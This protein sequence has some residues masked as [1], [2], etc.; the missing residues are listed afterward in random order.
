ME[1]H[2]W[3]QRTAGLLAVVGVA[4]ILFIATATE[5]GRVGPIA[6]QPD[7]PRHAARMSARQGP[8]HT[9]ACTPARRARGHYL[10]TSLTHC[11][12]CHSEVSYSRAHPLQ[13]IP[14]TMGSGHVFPP[15]ESGV[16]LP[17]RVVAPNITPD[18]ETGAGTW[19]DEQFMQA[20]RQGIGHDG[21]T[22]FPLMPYP[23]FHD[24]D[25]EDLKSV[26]CYVRS[27]PPIRR[28]MPP[29]VLPPAL[30]AALK[31]L[32]PAGHVS[33]PNPKDPVA[34]GKYLVKL[35]N[36]TGCHTPLDENFQ[37]LPGMY[38]AGGRV[39]VGPFGRVASLNLTP[40]PSSPI[41][42][43][44][45]QRFIR[46]IRTGEDGARLLS[47]FMPWGYY[48]HLTDS[49]LEAIYAYLRTISPVKHEVDNE[50][51]P[52]YC[53]LDKQKHGLGDLNAAPKASGQAAR[54]H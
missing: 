7:Q 9:I 18:P 29:T 5:P 51:A 31:P 21:R 30:R 27:I 42:A 15:E 19:T 53:P 39:F 4:G 44:D 48:R 8:L 3:A 24:M 52:T 46:T 1:P 25:D 49:D 17:Y 14:G 10:V 47:T 34:R 20:I 35:G 26:V 38:L 45:L 50:D 54:P 36:C 2:G 22:L 33:P 12:A 37:P 43:A 16:P 41:Y 6:H 11:F 40:D 32:P 28:K 13:P 23:L